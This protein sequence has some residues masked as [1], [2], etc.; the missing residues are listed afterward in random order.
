[1]LRTSDLP[2]ILTVGDDDQSIYR[3]Q[4]AN[5][6]NM[7]HFSQKFENTKIIVLDVNYRSGQAILDTARNL[8]E[9]NTT[10]ITS[11][12]PNIQKPLV[13]VGNKKSQVRISNYPNP[14]SEHSGVITRISELVHSGVS[15]TEIAI[16]VKKNAEITTWTNVLES[17]GIPVTSRQKYN[18]FDT[19]EFRLVQYLIEIIT[20]PKVP[21]FSL[22][23]LIRIGIF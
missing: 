6:G 2:N 15:H 18:L 20:L 17:H 3:F 4:G 19:E 8:I 10:R 12:I 23:E 11:L 9:K 5:L 1:L 7:L 16:L 13:S 14:E 22:I 21:D